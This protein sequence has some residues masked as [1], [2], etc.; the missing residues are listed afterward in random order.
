MFEDFRAGVVVVAPKVGEIVE[1]VCEKSFR[2]GLRS[3]PSLFEEV[4][5]IDEVPRRDFVKLAADEF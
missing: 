4:V 3:K 1:L 2:V 5:V